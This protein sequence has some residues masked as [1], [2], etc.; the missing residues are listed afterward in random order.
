MRSIVDV[1]DKE[2]MLLGYGWAS[3]VVRYGLSSEKLL[4]APITS[5]RDSTVQRAGE[6]TV[7]GQ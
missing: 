3:L 4:N 6:S 7:S 5:E 1:D 2:T